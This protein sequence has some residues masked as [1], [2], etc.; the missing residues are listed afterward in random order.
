MQDPAI[1][2]GIAHI[3]VMFLLFLFGLDLN[4]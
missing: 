2:L 1:T 4:P 3:G